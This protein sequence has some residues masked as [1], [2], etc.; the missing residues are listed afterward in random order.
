MEQLG[1]DM[2]TFVLSGFAA[3]SAFWLL[4][5]NRQWLL[6]IVFAVEAL[7]LFLLGVEF[8]AYADLKSG[9]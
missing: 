3:L 4:D 5:P 2:V 7:L 8:F 6:M 1:I 9:R